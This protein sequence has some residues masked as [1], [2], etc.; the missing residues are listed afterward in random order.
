MKYSNRFLLIVAMFVTC[1]ITANVIAVKLVEIGPVLVFAAIPI[2]PLSY[3]FGDVLTEVYGYRQARIVIWLGF[4]CN[5]IFVIFAWLGQIL[6]AAPFWHGQQAY[7]TILGNTPR[8]LVAS[9]AGYLAG[10]FSN[11]YIM[12]KVKIMTRGRWLWVRTISST[13]VGEGLDSFI[14][15]TLALIG[16]ES[17]VPV[18]IIYQWWIKVAIEVIATPFTYWAAN[19]LKKKESIDTYDYKTNFNPFRLK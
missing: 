16:T 3:I 7:E 10:E 13:I 8:L 12:A 4:F 9:F 17:F 11:S 6:P 5:L 14:F 15:A 2:F 18:I 1:L 19:T